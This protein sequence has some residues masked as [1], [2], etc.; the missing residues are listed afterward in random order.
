MKTGKITG[1]RCFWTP[2]IGR[3]RGQI[4]RFG[5]LD[6]VLGP[7]IHGVADGVHKVAN[8]GYPIRFAHT[9]DGRIWGN[10]ETED[11][12]IYRWGAACAAAP[13]EWAYNIH[14]LTDAE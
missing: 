2:K 6:L 10:A 8:Y 13:P 3:F 12:G 5:G 1:I 11:I 4:G 7:D 14:H 9:P